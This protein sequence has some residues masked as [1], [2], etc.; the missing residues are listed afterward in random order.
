MEGLLHD[1]QKPKKPISGKKNSQKYE[2]IYK[3]I[4]KKKHNEEMA[5]YSDLSAR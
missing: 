3:F 1:G 5:S 4:F 2:E